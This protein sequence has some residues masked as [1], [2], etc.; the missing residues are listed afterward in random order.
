MLGAE[1]GPRQLNA[2]VWAPRFW[3]EEF[4]ALGD[5]HKA[6][7]FLGRPLLSEESTSRIHNGLALRAKVG[8]G[9]ALGGVE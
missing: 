3:R 5:L 1:S 9:G 2:I 7:S 4:G 6:F 8:G